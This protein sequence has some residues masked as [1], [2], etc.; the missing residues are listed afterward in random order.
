MPGKMAGAVSRRPVASGTPTDVALVV[1]TG[2]RRANRIVLTVD[3][4]HGLR[5]VTFSRHCPVFAAI[6]IN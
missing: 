3:L 1:A 6:I 5:L 4:G 2:E